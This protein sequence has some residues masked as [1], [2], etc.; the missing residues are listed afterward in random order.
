MIMQTRFNEEEIKVLHQMLDKLIESGEDSILF[1]K[2]ELPEI[3]LSNLDNMENKIRIKEYR[4]YL[5]VNDR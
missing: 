3:D 1:Q 2:A 5:K 4:M